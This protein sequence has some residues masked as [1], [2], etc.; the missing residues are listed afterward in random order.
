MQ[1]FYFLFVT[2][3]SPEIFILTDIW[4]AFQDFI[5]LFKHS[6][7]AKTNVTQ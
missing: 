4:T 6:A 3:Y 5:T 1:I 2:I 7:R